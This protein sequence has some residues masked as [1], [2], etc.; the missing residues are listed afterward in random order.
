MYKN[1]RGVAKDEAEAVKWYRKAAEQN[2]DQAQYNLGNSYFSGQGVAT[3]YV[4][5]VKWWRQAAEQNYDQAQYTLGVCYRDGHGVATN[6]VEAVKWFR[7]A[8]EQDFAGAQS[9]LALLGGLEKWSGG[10]AGVF[11]GEAPEVSTTRA[12]L[13]LWR[14]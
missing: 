8:A 12:R 5:A 2:H 6:Y 13:R 1:G 14:R 3:N 10:F 9:N 11:E 7:K 4:E